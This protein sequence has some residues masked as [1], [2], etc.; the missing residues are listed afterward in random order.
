MARLSQRGC[1]RIFEEVVTMVCDELEAQGMENGD[2][3]YERV[4]DALS[5]DVLPGL[6]DLVVV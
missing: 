3:L 2:E 1:A 5:T 4:G 6:E